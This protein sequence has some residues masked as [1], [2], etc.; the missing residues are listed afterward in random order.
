M[1]DFW[2]ALILFICGLVGGGAIHSLWGHWNDRRKEN[3]DSQDSLAYK[4]GMNFGERR[5]EPMSLEEMYNEF[6]EDFWSKQCCSSPCINFQESDATYLDG[7]G[8][9]YEFM[10]EL[11]LAS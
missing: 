10:K 5:N 4:D 3:E 6:L 8:A 1:D 11:K 2:N 7:A 9:L